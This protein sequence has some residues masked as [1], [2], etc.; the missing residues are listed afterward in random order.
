MKIRRILFLINSLWELL[1]FLLLFLAVL[2]VLREALAANPQV[3]RWLLVLAAPG[4]L[5]PAG[6]LFIYL[7]PRRSA[8]LGLL[9]LGKVL[10]FCAAATLVLAAPFELLRAGLRLPWPAALPAAI[11][12]GTVAVDIALLLPLVARGPGSAEGSGP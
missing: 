7:D 8:L 12:A 2:L 9:Q 1:R 6:Y 11:L 5:L 4:L 3:A 10:A